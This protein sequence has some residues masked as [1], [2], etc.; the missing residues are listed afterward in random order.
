MLKG[1][2]LAKIDNST[3]RTNAINLWR[4]RIQ[5]FNNIEEDLENEFFKAWL[6]SQYA[7]KIRERK[8]DAKPEDFDLIGTQYHRWLR[9][10][11]ATIGLIKGSDFFRFINTDFEFYSQQYLRLIR[12]SIDIVPGLEHVAYNLDHGFTL[13]YMVLLA[14]LQVNDDAD[15]V[16]RK[17]RITARFLDILINRRMWNG[18]S[19]AYSTLQYAMFLLMRDIRKLDVESLA[20]KLYAELQK[21]DHETFSGIDVQQYNSQNLLA[22]SLNPACYEHNPG[23]LQFVRRSNLPFKAHPT[24]KSDDLDQRGELYRQI[25]QKL[26]NPQTLLDEISK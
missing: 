11:S 2:L 4:S 7:T 17:V 1:Y 5:E 12:A 25:A 10:A 9:D 16:Q 20:H 8:K 23:F 21:P 22:R 6:R 15:T 24:F 26:W 19:T 13:Q 14:P 3:Q 18:R